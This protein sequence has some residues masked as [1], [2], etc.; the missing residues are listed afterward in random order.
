M[1][2]ELGQRVPPRQTRRACCLSPLAAGQ[3]L[4]AGC[5]LRRQGLQ[6]TPRTS[7]LLSLLAPCCAGPTCCLSRRRAA[8]LMSTAAG[9]CIARARR[10][11][12]VSMR[13][14]PAHMQLG[15]QAVCSLRCWVWRTSCSG[16]APELP[17]CGT[18]SRR[19]SLHRAPRRLCPTCPAPRPPWCCLSAL[20][21]IAGA[22][23]GSRPRRAGLLGLGPGV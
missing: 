7:E 16:S 11:A 17:C 14:Y 22:C 15:A 5:C 2:Q 23:S 13:T 4:S 10:Q 1:Q 3:I 8:G 19:S 21:R 20:V 9:V 12:V 18:G 6:G